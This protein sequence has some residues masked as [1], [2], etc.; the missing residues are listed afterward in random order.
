MLPKEIMDLFWRS[1]GEAKKFL[2]EQLR[3]LMGLATL[4]PLETIPSTSE[5]ASEH[6]PQGQH[7]LSETHSIENSFVRWYVGT[8]LGALRRLLRNAK[9]VGIDGPLNAIIGKLTGSGKVKV[10]GDTAGTI[11]KSNYDGIPK[12]ENSLPQASLHAQGRGGMCWWMRDR[13]VLALA[14]EKN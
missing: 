4:R 1:I 9:K 8:I 6:E 7:Q 13:L 11:K 3:L 10:T 14:P 2:V 5:H 12:F